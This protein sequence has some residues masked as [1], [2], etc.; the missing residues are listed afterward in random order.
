MR[1]AIRLFPLLILSLTSLAAAQTAPPPEPS[2]EDEVQDLTGAPPPPPAP[3]TATT[4]PSSKPAA[5]AAP[6]ATPPE[7]AAAPPVPAVADESRHD[8]TKPW[9]RDGFYLRVM[10][11]MGA[12]FVSGDGP[13]GRVWTSGGGNSSAIAIGGS[14]APGLVL[15]GTVQSSSITNTLHR[16]PFAGATVTT[17]DGRSMGASAKAIAGFSQLGLLVDWYPDPSRGWRAGLSGGLGLAGLVNQADDSTMFGT[18]LAGSVFGGY[19]WAIGP[20]WSM[21]LALIASGNTSAKL[22]NSDGDST[23]YRLQSFSVGLAGS[24]L[25]F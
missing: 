23:G 11:G 16:G 6:A 10:S 13:R 3:A 15:A 2:S 19:D 12:M 8:C 4:A 17:S 24:I 14:V 22:M 21:G 5:A 1:L 25:Y 20:S 9:K 18:S 7:A